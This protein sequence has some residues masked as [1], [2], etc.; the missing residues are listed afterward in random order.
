MARIIILMEMAS[1]ERLS[2][3]LAF[4]VILLT[5]IAVAAFAYN[6][7]LLFYVVAAIVIALGFYFAYR[8]SKET[9]PKQTRQR[10]KA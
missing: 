6:S 2:L 9:R 5:V 8:V 10:K 4:T 3:A 1:S 7:M